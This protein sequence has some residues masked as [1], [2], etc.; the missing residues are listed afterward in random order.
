[1]RISSALAARRADW[2]FMNVDDVDGLARQIA[3]IREMA[4]P[5]GAN[6]ASV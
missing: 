3:A 4:E 2:Y 5:W 1:L 6:P